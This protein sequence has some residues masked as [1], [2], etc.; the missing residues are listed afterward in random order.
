M[1]AFTEEERAQLARLKTKQLRINYEQTVAWW[2]Q[3]APH[4]RWIYPVVAAF[5]IWS[6]AS[7]WILDGES[8]WQAFIIILSTMTSFVL[9]LSIWVMWITHRDAKRWL[10]KNA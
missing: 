1:T 3:Y 9:L 7:W 6:L 2:E 10:E 8:T 5:C 4:R